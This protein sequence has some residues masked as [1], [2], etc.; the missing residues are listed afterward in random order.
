MLRREKLGK[1]RTAEEPRRGQRG[2]SFSLRPDLLEALQSLS[3]NSGKATTQEIGS[4]SN[5]GDDCL[6]TGDVYRSHTLCYHFIPF[7]CNNAFFS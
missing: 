7:I 4:K 3:A 1:F 5:P 6:P 2:F